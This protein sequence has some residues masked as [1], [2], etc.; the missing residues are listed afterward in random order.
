[1]THRVDDGSGSKGPAAASSGVNSES[2]FYNEQFRSIIYQV[3]LILAVVGVGYYLVDN[4]LHNLAVRGIATGFGYL[5]SE[6]GFPISEA[7][8]AYSATDAYG[9]ALVVGILNT[10]KIAIVGIILASLLGTIVGIARL[11][12]NWLVAKLASVYVETIRNIPLLL[13]LFVW[14]GVV[15]SLL[16]SP[17]DAMNPIDGVFLSNRG[18]K[19]PIMAEHPIWTW[20][21]LAIA[22]GFVL[23]WFIGRWADKR[24]A[25]TGVR[26]STLLPVLAAIVGLPM[27]VWLIGGAPTQVDAPALR[28]FNFV[29]GMSVSPEYAALLIGLVTYTAS[30]IAEI[31]RSGIQA[32]NYGQTEASKALGLSSGHILRLVILPQS[33]RVIIPPVTS[34]YLNL[35]KNSSLAVA[36]GYPDLVSV[37]NTTL[38]QTGQAIEA[39]AIMMAVYLFL[40]LATSAFMNWYNTRIAL[41]ER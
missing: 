15:T 9:R 13:Q 20:V 33:L 7:P 28:G 38:N 5:R 25:D 26:P 37:T 17:R 40:S 1:M 29:G 11:S 31:V 6:A 30:F 24:Q 39:I 34:Q 23:V 12:S 18:F 36:I 16:P 8:V 2:W 22:V 27:I 3:V 19:F 10:I 35:T 41:V 32:V 14:Y 4:T 21:M